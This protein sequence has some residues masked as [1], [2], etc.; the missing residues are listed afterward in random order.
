MS[1]DNFK[2]H[3]IQVSA[4]AAGSDYQPLHDIT[5][6]SCVSPMEFYLTAMTADPTSKW[7]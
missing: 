1:D 7:D 5:K 4:P 6:Y 3:G 2:T